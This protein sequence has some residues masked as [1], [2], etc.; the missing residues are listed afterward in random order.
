[1]NY[2]DPRPSICGESAVVPVD[3]VLTAL[4]YAGRQDIVPADV[5]DVR[6]TLQAHATDDH[7]AFVVEVTATTGAWTRW[8]EG[9]SPEVVLVLSDCPVTDPDGDGTCS[10]YELHPGGH[11]WQVND[12]LNTVRLAR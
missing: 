2:P 4:R 3:V 9:G 12:P 8:A 10:E 7:Y 1:M 5:Q 11:T 6:C